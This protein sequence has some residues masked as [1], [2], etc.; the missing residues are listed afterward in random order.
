MLISS[1]FGGNPA[2]NDVAA[3]V[4]TIRA[5]EVSDSV[6][7]IQQAL[8]TVGFDL[9][10][11]GV[12]R[13][14]RSETGVAVSTF[15]ADRGLSPADPVVGSGTINR[16]DLELSYLDGSDNPGFA[17]DATLLLSEPFTAAV[18]DAVHPDLDITRIVLDALELNDKFCFSMSMA[19]LDAPLIASFVGRL[20]EP[21]VNADFCAQAGPCSAVDDFFD[22][23]NSPVPYTTF[24]AAHNPGINPATISD[25]GS[26]VRPDIISHHPDLTPEWYEIKPLSPAGVAAGLVKG[27]A[28][29]DGYADNGFPYIPGKRYK[30]SNEILLGQF[31]TPEGEK[32]DVFIAA[33]R[34]L[35]G[36]IFYRLCLRGDFVQYFN[37]VRLAAGIL[38]IL[39]ALAPELTVAGAAAEEVETF[40]NLVKA[41][42]T[43]VGVTT[44]PEVG[45]A[46]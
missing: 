3:G 9:P 10:E 30:P 46:L 26:G 16:L 29:K 39:V 17:S 31:I 45:P 35:P 20:V 38:A 27:N 1:L 18:L 41:A 42:A 44:L 36:L 37:R 32:L 6:A 14:F 2:L 34:L 21:H 22:L 13:I 5:P 25:V 19:I 4:R 33:R 12:D 24:L 23:L 8:V 15:K 43:A 11:A 28:L 40:I 7:L